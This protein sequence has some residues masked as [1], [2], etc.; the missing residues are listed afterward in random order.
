M[1]RVY[2]ADGT[3]KV[4]M[5]DVDAIHDNVAGEIAIIA[6]KGALVAGDFFVIEDSAVSNAKKSVLF[7]VLESSLT[8]SGI[9]GTLQLTDLSDVGGTT[10]SGTT[11][12]F[13]D[14]PQF[15][16]T[17]TTTGKFVTTTGT[18]S[19]EI[20]NAASSFQA[21][22]GSAV[23][24]EYTF[25]G[26]GESDNNELFTWK[27]DN[28]ASGGTSTLSIAI[29]ETDITL[30]AAGAT[31]TLT[32][33]T[34]ASFTNAQHDHSGAG[35]AGGLIA[36]T[37]LTGTLA[38]GSGGTGQTAAD[39]A[40][41]ALSPTT[42]KGDL[43]V[44]GDASDNIRVPIGTNTHVLTADSTLAAG[45]KWV[46]PSG[47]SNHDILSS[48][49]GDSTP[50]AIVR[51]DIIIGVGVTPKWTRL[52]TDAAT[53]VL[54]GG[55][56]P[57]YSAV[58]MAADVT[59]ILPGAN[60]G[61]NS[62][63]VAF[64]G[65]TT[66]LKTFTLPDA[67]ATIF[68][69][70]SQTGT[71]IIAVVSVAP[72]FTGL[73]TFATNVS[74]LNNT[75]QIQWGD[76]TTAV[77]TLRFVGSGDSD[78][79]ELA[80]VILDNQGSG[81]TNQLVID[82][83]DTAVTLSATALLTLTAPT[84][85]GPIIGTTDW[86]AALHAHEAANSGGVLQTA[87]IADEA[88]T[89]AKLVHSKEYSLKG[90]DSAGTGD[91]TD[92]D[93]TD[94][95]SATPAS[96]D[97]LVGWKSTGV[98]NK[99]DVGNL[100]AG[101]EVNNL[102]VVTTGINNN[103]V[104]VGTALDTAAYLALPT[105]GAVSFNGTVFAQAALANLSD[106]ASTIGTGDVVPFND[107]PTLL[108]IVEFSG[109]QPINFSTANPTIAWGVTDVNPSTL[110]FDGKS[111]TDASNL[112]TY[113]FTNEG[114]AGTNALQV[115]VNDIQ[116]ILTADT[117]LNFTSTSSAPF[118][119][120]NSNAGFN[121]G[122]GSTGAE[123]FNFRGKG[124]SDN[125]E[126]FT[127]N[128]SND[129]SGG[130]SI[131]S[132]AIDETDITLSASGAT[133]TL[134]TPTIASFAN[135]GHV[136][137]GAASGGVLTNSTAT[138]SAIHDD[139]DGEINALTDIGTPA[140]GDVLLIEDADASF[141]KK[142]VLISS[143][144]AGGEIN[145]L[146][147][148]G[149]SGSI[150]NQLGVGTG[151][152]A[153]EYLTLST[154]GAVSFSGTAFTQAAL[155]DL[156]DVTLTSGSGSTVA[157]V[158]APAFINTVTFSG[159]PQ[160][161]NASPLDLT[162]ATP[163]IFWSV[164][165]VN[166]STLTFRGG[167]DTDN[168]HLS[169][170]VFD[171]QRGAGTSAFN[172]A[173]N[174]TDVTLSATGA[175]LTL[176]APTIGATDWAAATHTH[177]DASRGGTLDAAAIATGTLLHEQGGLEADVSAGDGFVEIKGTVTTVIK[178]NLAAAIAPVAGDDSGSGYAVG[179]RWIDTTA[180]KEYVCLDST[181]AAAVWTETTGAGGGGTHPVELASD[182]NGILPGANGGTNN[183]FMDFTGPTTS[184]KTFTLP[185]ASA[186]IFTNATKSGTGNTPVVDDA[187]TLQNIV[188]FSGTSPID[189]TTANPT[190]AWGVSDV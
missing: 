127:W 104:A 111:D 53:T 43:I 172:V 165:D 72:D 112:S 114:G 136:H 54:H 23:I 161:T 96:G 179:S 119:L 14:N 187:P 79:G 133:L 74:F 30:S 139:I 36:I 115:A 93:E 83:N 73:P 183:G 149:M 19:V 102:S 18:P 42:T 88:I 33:P 52:A 25:T 90:R 48:T 85:T 47:G 138:P 106:V 109:T 100:P 159:S 182:V 22:T 78:N 155:D 124:E 181:G 51:G 62:E 171:N 95:A 59:G 145:A 38:I 9:G 185:D 167:S 98:L 40:F 58:D 143:L 116:V 66:S 35:A 39:E 144:P 176:S 76:G 75:P 44:M 154:A 156:S 82:V 121:V 7:S 141:A 173:I 137:T 130:T 61:T 158:D 86:A 146:A 178:T 170:Y 34:I 29:N 101:G 123:A 122:L 147:A 117:A 97:F 184:L 60:G 168:G 190:V 169:T 24:Q 46:A 65:P 20:Q 80:T 105:T 89:N 50:A 3:E 118:V 63:F 152:G 1:S 8:L 162:H 17:V 166:P 110:V 41:D 175:T 11:L 153:A 68:T 151:A 164:A 57:S 45:L 142:K 12:T 129:G 128:F 6:A 131:L 31:L 107:A 135:A 189:L 55:T 120:N 148:D 134:T 16:N 126:L 186:I 15:T 77:Q 81:G 180:D 56:E 160:F 163:T 94:I 113:R 132:I 99:F 49:H 37:D 27:F 177:A 26:E 157:F 84:I 125:S 28:T 150:D 71:G 32:T 13:N 92:M 174:E 69:S 188:T 4:K 10:G 91:P 67:S 140:S 2:L 70:N 21:G 5:V 87:A 108:N 64:T 103:E